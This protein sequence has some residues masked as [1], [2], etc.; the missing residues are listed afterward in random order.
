[1]NVK[2]IPQNGKF[3]FGIAI[4]IL[5]LIANA[6]FL[7]F[8]AFRTFN[9]LDMGGFL[10]ASWRVFCGQRPYRDFIYSS[11]PFH[12][13][14]NALFFKIFGFGKTAILAHLI[15]IHSL[16]IISVYL[17]LFPRLPLTLTLAGTLL[18][19]PSFYWGVSHPWHDQTAH[20]LGILGLT[21]L[22]T[23]APFTKKIFR[24]TLLSA[25]FAA[26]A[27]ATKVN[28]GFAYWFVFLVISTIS[29]QRKRALQG[30]F[31]GSLLG[32]LFAGAIIR[33]P[34]EYWEQLSTFSRTTEAF[35][36]LANFLFIKQWFVNYYWIAFVLMII[37]KYFTTQK[38]RE[39]FA[40]FCGIT[41]IGIF[42]INT[43]G[44][45]QEA[46]NFLWGVQIS[47]AYIL[48]YQYKD[49]YRRWGE[50]IFKSTMA[51]LLSLTLFLFV[52]SVRY[53]WQLKVWTY[54]VDNP[55]GDY[56]LTIKPLQGWLTH[57][58]EGKPLEKLVDFV[59]SYV[60]KND[61]LLNLS[62]MYVIYALT[63][64]ESYPHIPFI[65]ITDIF[66][67]HGR[68]AKEVKKAILQNPP[69]WIILHRSSYLDEIP[70]LGIKTFINDEYKI[71]ARVGFYYVLKRK[72]SM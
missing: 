71:I 51:L 31:L 32:S 26:I 16:V 7:N 61:R 50:I 44:V 46:N 47:L 3:Y 29:F 14:L 17:M 68:Q 5:I 40:L 34:F 54:S 70:A 52:V 27:I 49:N 41:F 57:A 1:M 64:R 43:G 11:G 62:N 39:L 12:L 25:F 48:L 59:N 53:G 67:A 56:A 66:P 9:F 35:S 4:L 6:F 36:R 18:T 37:N 30:F 33:Y 69:K 45:I 55:V 42:T 22:V 72:D 60:G 65:F 58:P 8:N 19:V 15:T 23:H 28:V 2:N 21:L 63:G 10:D 38:C 13:Y 20:F 24:Y